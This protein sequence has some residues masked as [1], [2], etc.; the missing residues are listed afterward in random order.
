MAGAILLLA[1]I[2]EA[3]ERVVLE[4]IL[5]RVNDRIVTL[6][7]F[8]IRLLQEL[9]QRAEPPRGADLERFA[10]GLFET[11]VDELILLERAQ[12]KR[13]TVD[14]AMVD[15]SIEA[16]RE[17]NGLQDDAAFEEAL[18]GAG[19]TVD[20]LR[21]RYRQSIALSRVVQSEVQPAEITQEEVRQ[22]YEKEKE[23]FKVPRKVRLEQL[24]F[25][26]AEDG[27]DQAAVRDRA[28]GLLERVGRGADLIAEATLAGVEVQ[29]LGAIPAHDLRPELTDLLSGLSDGQLTDPLYAAGGYQVIRLL[30]RIPEGYEPFEDVSEQLRRELSSEAYRE[31]SEG[32]VKQLRASYLVEVNR[33]LLDRALTGLIDG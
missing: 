30:E 31:Q 15:R 32:L 26:V 33:D 3:T 23:R 16:L 28:E 5:V 7:D 12:E 17:E 19:L 13:L 9:T 14:D 18:T 27:S 22:R 24:F 8:R 20:D 10:H 11:V 4:A 21:R 25:P 6:S 1:I 2:A 29:E